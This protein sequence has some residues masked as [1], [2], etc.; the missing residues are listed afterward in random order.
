MKK[1]SYKWLLSGL[2]LSLIMPV[3]SF[4]AVQNQSGEYA[5]STYEELA[6]AVAAAPEGATIIIT[7]DLA[8]NES[9]EILKTVTI[10]GVT[11]E[12]TLSAGNLYHFTVHNAA[13]LTLEDLHLYGGSQWDTSGLL[14]Y[15]GN[16]NLDNT[17]IA[18]SSFACTSY[19]N[20]SIN[21][22]GGEFYDLGTVISGGKEVI[23]HNG[24]FHGN[25]DIITETRQVEIYGG[26]FYDNEHVFR[27]PHE[28]ITITGGRFTNNKQV[29]RSYSGDITVTGGEFAYNQGDDNGSVIYSEMGDITI[30]GGE[31][32]YNQ[33]P[34]NGGVIYS[35]EGNL[36]VSGGYFANNSSGKGG[37][38]YSEPEVKVLITG[39]IFTGN[40]ASGGGAVHANRDNLAI[41]E[42]A[43]FSNNRADQAYYL[44]AQE[45]ITLHEQQIDPTVTWTEGFDYIYN[46]LDVA[47]TDG[48]TEPVIRHKATVIFVYDEDHEQPVF[49]QTY[50]VPEYSGIGV[51]FEFMEEGR[52]SLAAI[53][54]DDRLVP[55]PEWGNYLDMEHKN[56]IVNMFTNDITVKLIFDNKPQV[57]ITAWYGNDIIPEFSQTRRIAHGELLE[58]NFQAIDMNAYP[59]LTV[60]INEQPVGLNE[61]PLD[62]NMEARILWL[63]Q[64]EQ[65][66]SIALIFTEA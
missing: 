42:H 44:N 34:G 10:K 46:N 41:R 43:G 57:N 64:I 49:S 54:I 16:L 9:L 1:Q 39:G 15:N 65:D 37:V 25:S 21:I 48:L 27:G 31:F 13:D 23:I 12:T 8:F 56:F 33:N 4:A 52:N 19:G 14:L 28:N 30:T 35:N 6:E 50:L 7:E 11:P 66:C 17:V 62:T 36:T 2:F 32:T 61:W 59:V 29:I 51:N 40:S 47:Y 18:N 26:S 5:A 24:E 45:D 22:T 38:L 53:Y 58:V 20:S 55:E 63:H 3:I 60:L